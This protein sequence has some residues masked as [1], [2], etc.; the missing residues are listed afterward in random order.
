MQTRLTAQTINFIPAEI[1]KRFDVKVGDIMAWIDD[2]QEIKVV[3]F[4]PDIVQALKGTGK[5]YRSLERLLEDR[6]TDDK[7]RLSL[8]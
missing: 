5:S 7:D 1:R 2:G 3:F 6:R 8:A 4:P